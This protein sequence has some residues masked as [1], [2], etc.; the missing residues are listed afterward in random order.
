MIIIRGEKFKNINDILSID[1]PPL[2]IRDIQQRLWEEADERDLDF[3]NLECLSFIA[4]MNPCWQIE[5]S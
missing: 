1:R 4:D 5:I 3:P 2:Y